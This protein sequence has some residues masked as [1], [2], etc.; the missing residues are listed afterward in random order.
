MAPPS[1][2]SRLLRIAATILAVLAGGTAV[3]HAAANVDF[4][5][6]GDAPSSA[7]AGQ[8][9]FPPAAGMAPGGRRANRVTMRNDGGEPV[10]LVLHIRHTDGVDADPRL[11]Q[12]LELSIRDRVTG[13]V[14]RTL[15]LA[16]AQPARIAR[17]APGQTGRYAAQVRFVSPRERGVRDGA[18]N[19]LQGATC[20][21]DF[22]WSFAAGV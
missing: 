15:T 8:A 16:R 14:V 4:D 19:A 17:L 10:D 18:Q 9:L 5:T 12:A 21:A 11:C 22:A 6:A 1:P 3:A 2:T 13:R 7:R 20:G